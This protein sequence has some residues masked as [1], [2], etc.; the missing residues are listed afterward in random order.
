[1]YVSRLLRPL[2]TANAI[3]RSPHLPSV[4]TS[5]LDQAK[6]ATAIHQ[7]KV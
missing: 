3:M 4:L 7:L 6:V 2:W 1:M 5:A